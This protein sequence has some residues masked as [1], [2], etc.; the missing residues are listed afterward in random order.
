MRLQFAERRNVI[1]GNNGRRRKRAKGERGG[2]FGGELRLMH[3]KSPTAQL[4]SITRST[5]HVLE[6]AFKETPSWAP[7][8][9]HIS[10]YLTPP[11]PL[12]CLK[13]GRLFICEHTTRIP[14]MVF[15]QDRYY[16]MRY[17]GS[18]TSLWEFLM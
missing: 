1:R 2:R 17:V 4:L 7:L 9:L 8:A 12:L 10:L 14:L 3:G 11:S 18:H 5:A 15:P 13:V 6:M 16:Q